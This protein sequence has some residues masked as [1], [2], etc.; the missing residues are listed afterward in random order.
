MGG[1]T[2]LLAKRIFIFFNVLVAIVFLLA[3]LASYLN[4][5]HWWYISL[6]GLGF[7]IVL[8]LLVFFVFFWLLFHPKY[9]LISIIALAI[10][11]KSIAV[12]FAFNAAQSPFNYR[13]PKNVLRIASWNVARFTE[14]RRNNNRGSHIR[15][16][17]MEQIKAQ[18]ADVVCMQEFFTS[19]D[20]IYYNNIKYVQEKLNYPYVYFSWDG[21]GYK[22][23]F[24][25]AIFSRYPIIDSGLVHYPRPTQRESLIHADIVFNNDTVRIYNTHLQ[26]VQFK[27]NDFESIEKIKNRDEDSLLLSSRNIFQKLKRGLVNRS[28]Q[29]QIV[30]EVIANSP[31]PFL[32]CGDFNDVPNSYT[33]FTV[34]GNLQDAFLQKGFGIGR[35]F[36]GISPTLRIDYILATPDFS[37]QQFNRIKKY[38]SDHYMLVA[39]MALPAE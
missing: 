13:K 21:D 10:G 38:L 35:T 22:Q 12:F 30:K 9:S 16:K 33:Y 36:S 14:W 29:V 2:G 27:K 37:V 3:C 6:L 23:Y 28:Q 39:D 8:V 26:S 18:N 19:T 32:L 24:G 5:E 7:P 20:S 31:H 34:K 15:L 11:W 17:M 1:K 25:Q 4:P